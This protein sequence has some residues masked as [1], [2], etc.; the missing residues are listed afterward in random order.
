MIAGSLG[1]VRAVEVRRVSIGVIGRPERRDRHRPLGAIYLLNTFLLPFV[2]IRLIGNGKQT[3]ALKLVL[4]L[5]VGP[6][7]LVAIK[8][9]AKPT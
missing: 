1:A 4:Q 9:A 7:R 3:G 8:L 2:A 6:N 5:P